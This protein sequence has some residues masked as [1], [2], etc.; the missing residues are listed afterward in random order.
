MELELII[1]DVHTRRWIK[2]CR[3]HS[4]CVFVEDYVCSVFCNIVDFFCLRH[5]VQ[6][7]RNMPPK[8]DKK[9]K[10]N[11]GP[12]KVIPHK[13]HYARINHLYGAAN[14][15][16][17]NKRH[18]ILSRHCARQLDL[19]AKKA[20]LKLTPAVKRTLCKKC[21]A[22]MIPGLSVEIFI[23]NLSNLKSPKSDVLVHR[24]ME[25]NTSKRYPIGIN[26][27]YEVFSERKDVAHPAL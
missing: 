4:L 10:T 9:E 25:C 8:K 15:L 11:G 12:P 20:V 16:A 27:A 26:R 7:S 22:M 19:V 1:V 6:K 14:L 13:D 5:L 24:C 2:H 3:N 18:S 17:Q 23:E 21:H